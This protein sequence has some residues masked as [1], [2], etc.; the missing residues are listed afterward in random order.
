MKLEWASYPNQASAYSALEIEELPETYMLWES[1]DDYIGN[2]KLA[3]LNKQ[4]GVKPTEGL[5]MRVWTHKRVFLQPQ[6]Q[7]N[8]SP[9]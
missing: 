6:H 1:L 3:Q 9:F 2:W 7:V 8:G 4:L 5:Q